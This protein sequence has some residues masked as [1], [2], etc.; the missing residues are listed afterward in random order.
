MAHDE[1]WNA[2]SLAK[3]QNMARFDGGHKREIVSVLTETL[4][5]DREK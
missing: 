5:D 1:R 3:R 4:N 2:A